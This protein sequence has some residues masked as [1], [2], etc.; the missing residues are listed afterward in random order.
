MEN[1][2]NQPLPK[3]ATGRMTFQ[4]VI[5]AIEPGKDGSTVELTGAAD[6]KLHIVLSIPNLG[7][8]STFDFGAFKI[9]TKIEVEGEVFMLGQRRRMAAKKALVLP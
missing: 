3:L 2:P 7:P 4:G 1:G 8:E 5:T 6:Q 9:G